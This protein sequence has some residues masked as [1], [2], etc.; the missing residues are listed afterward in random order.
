[1][2]RILIIIVLLVST[3]SGVNA[4]GFS[5]LFSSRFAKAVAL[6]GAYTSIAT[7]PEAVYYNPA[8][9]SLGADQYA[10][11]FSYGQAEQSLIDITP[12]D[13]VALFPRITGVGRFGISYSYFY[14]SI[15][16]FDVDFKNNHQLFRVSYSFPVASNFSLGL[17]ATYYTREYQF[18]ETGSFGEILVRQLTDVA[19]DMDLGLLYSFKDIDFISSRDQV[20]LGLQ[21]R[22]LF[23]GLYKDYE[24]SEEENLFQDLRLGISYETE[25]ISDDGENR[26]NYTL[27]FDSQFS[28]GFLIADLYEFQIYEPQIGFEI[29]Y[30]RLISLRLGY[31]D[32]VN[33]GSDDIGTLQTPRYHFGIGSYF[34]IIDRMNTELS[35]TYGYWVNQDQMDEFSNIVGNTTSDK[36]LVSLSLYFE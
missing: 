25:K 6:G 30:G 36:F 29:G 7:G 8:G 24:T 27:S 31:V 21:M 13:I 2:N 35:F 16:V 26:Y 15:S 23:A 28:S 17:N 9:L 10:A 3:I 20:N 12:F 18:E 4:Q 14:N 11:A 32:W 22:N 19:I 33:I 5:D 34:S 1:M